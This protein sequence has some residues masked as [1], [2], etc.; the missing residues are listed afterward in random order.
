M[1]PGRRIPR[2]EAPPPDRPPP[3]D[4]A[5]V[6]APPVVANAAGELTALAARIRICEACA[7]ASGERVYGTGYPRAAV[8]LLADRPAEGDLGCG[9]AFSAFAEP[10][11]RAFTALGIPLGWVYGS[12]AVRCATH[13]PSSDELKACA[14]HLLVE[15]E[16]VGPRVIVAF[17]NHIAME[18][19]FDG[20][21]QRIFGAAPGEP[22]PRPEPAVAQQQGAVARAA[23][24]HVS[25]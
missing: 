23:D 8:M 13:T 16:A 5:D 21:L 1:A 2:V 4:G 18:E 22:A 7:R 15:V 17:G 9:S 14:S 10:L 20:S 11:D 6:E 25:A 3:P 12:T 24:H 19:T